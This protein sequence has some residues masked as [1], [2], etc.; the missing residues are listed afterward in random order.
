MDEFQA[1]YYLTTLRIYLIKTQF[2]SRLFCNTKMNVLS[3]HH[4]RTFLQGQLCWKIFPHPDAVTSSLETLGILYRVSWR[5]VGLNKARG[6]W[7][8]A[9]HQGP[10][11]WQ[12][13]RAQGSCCFFCVQASEQILQ[14]TQ[15]N[16]AKD[17]VLLQDSHLLHCKV[18]P[19]LSSPFKIEGE[20]KKNH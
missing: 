9:G 10:I 16:Q 1:K 18:I 11:H 13:S 12:H 19:L 2:C 6:T 4:S 15:Q 5:T 8:T 7:C 17:R 3:F 14:S 20:G